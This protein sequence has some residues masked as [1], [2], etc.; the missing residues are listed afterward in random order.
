MPHGEGV[1]CLHR[2]TSMS[3]HCLHARKCSHYAWELR[4]HHTR[5]RLQSDVNR[6]R[7]T[8]VAIQGSSDGPV[9]WTGCGGWARNTSSCV[10]PGPGFSD[11]CPSTCDMHMAPHGG[12]TELGAH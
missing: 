9:L 5:W 11:F 10:R 6:S 4:D 3:H 8:S 1:S 12:W 2:I 7:S